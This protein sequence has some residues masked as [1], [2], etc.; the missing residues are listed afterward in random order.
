M[1]NIINLK[2]Y[3]PEK[4]KKNVNVLL[5]EVKKTFPALGAFL[6]II[7]K[8]QV[9]WFII[10]GIFQILGIIYLITLIIKLWEIL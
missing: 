4:K 7:P 2:N 6:S 8:K 9:K 10:S 3:K 5:K 1:G